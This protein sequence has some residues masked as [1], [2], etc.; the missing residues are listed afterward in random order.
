[1]FQTEPILYLQSHASGALHYVFVIWNHLGTTAV[2]LLICA[3]LFGIEGKKGFTLLHLVVVV[4]ILSELLKDFFALPRPLFV[5][6]NI[7]YL[8]NVRENDAPFR[9][10]G[11]DSFFGPL[12]QQVIDYYRASGTQHWG[13]PSGH[14]SSTFVAWMGLALLQKKRWLAVLAT[15]V[16]IAVALARM[17]V[18]KHFLADVL[19]GALLG[20]LLLTLSYIFIIRPD[21]LRKAPAGLTLRTSDKPLLAYLLFAPL[22]LLFAQTSQTVAIACL[23]GINVGFVV[24]KG[25]PAV[26]NN[27]KKNNGLPAGVLA[28]ATLLALGWLFQST[29]GAAANIHVA[30]QAITAAL[31]CCVFIIAGRWFG[32]LSRSIS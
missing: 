10:M 19:A 14:V 30:V 16:T 8:D 9:A 4:A 1:M 31:L 20:G 7:Q 12:P 17:Y 15:V 25:L 24:A 22:P 6:N 23:L 26:M 18:G 21:R 28:V 13:L 5:D 32:P 27:G 2:A 29:V 3:F 11:A